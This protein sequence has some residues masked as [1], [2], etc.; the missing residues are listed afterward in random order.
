MPELELLRK[1]Y[2]DTISWM[3]SFNLVLA[4]I[5]EREDQDN[6]VDEL[7]CIKEDGLSLKIRGVCS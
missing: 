5:Q 1:Y 2:S 7:T 4:N 6:V 3:S